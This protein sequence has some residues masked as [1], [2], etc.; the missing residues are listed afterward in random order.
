LA[1]LR[2]GAACGA[3]SM[4][5]ASLLRVV[6]RGRSGGV[7]TSVTVT[8]FSRSADHSEKRGQALYCHFGQ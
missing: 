6:W 8:G 2:P 7:T 4:P 5:T 3:D 1:D